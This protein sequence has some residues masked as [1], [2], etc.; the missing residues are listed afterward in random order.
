[1]ITPE[2]D[3]PPVACLSTCATGSMRYRAVYQIGDDHARSRTVFG[4]VAGC[5]TPTRFASYMLQ[6][7]TG[8][9]STRT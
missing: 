3:A 2:P 8:F 4:N 1:M 6:R 9:S 7:Q 5:S